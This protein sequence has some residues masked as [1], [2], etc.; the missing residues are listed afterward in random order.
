MKSPWRIRPPPI[1]S[2]TVVEHLYRGE[3]H[4][5]TAA[6]AEHVPVDGDPNAIQFT[7]PVKAGTKKSFTYTVRYTW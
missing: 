1:A 3:T 6:S 5:I 7:V 4:E 2:I